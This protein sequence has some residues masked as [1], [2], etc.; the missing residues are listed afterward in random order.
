MRSWPFRS[1]PWRALY[2]SR[3]GHGV[4]TL[5]VQLRQGDKGRGLNSVKS[6]PRGSHQTPPRMTAMFLEQRTSVSICHLNRDY[7]FGQFHRPGSHHFH[8]SRLLRFPEWSCI[9]IV[10]HQLLFKICQGML[11]KRKWRLANQKLSL[12]LQIL[13]TLHITLGIITGRCTAP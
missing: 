1:L 5:F 11:R 2:N 13:D 12:S 7:L 4:T 6:Y 10:L 3:G 9:T 8:Y